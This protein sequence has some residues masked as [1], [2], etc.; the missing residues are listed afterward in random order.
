ME[1]AE[2]V[3]VKVLE[4]ERSHVWRTTLHTLYGGGT[5]PEAVLDSQFGNSEKNRAKH[6]IDPSDLSALKSAAQDAKA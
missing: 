6:Y 2:Q 5:V 1:I 3:G 4:N